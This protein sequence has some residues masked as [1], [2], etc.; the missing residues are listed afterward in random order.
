MS[1]SEICNMNISAAVSAYSS[2]SADNSAP[3]NNGA[4]EE[5]A[6]P[7]DLGRFSLS[8]FCQA[9]CRKTC[10]APGQSA[11]ADAAGAEN[12]AEVLSILNAVG[13]ILRW[14][15]QLLLGR[16]KFAPGGA[17]MEATAVRL[18]VS[19]DCTKKPVEMCEAIEFK[20]MVWR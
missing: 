5:A 13:P 11:T 1:V 6:A 15:T 4:L 9:T 8:S 20:I 19:L 18:L 10:G 3:E 12:R 17:L 7:Q 14:D 16:P 2:S